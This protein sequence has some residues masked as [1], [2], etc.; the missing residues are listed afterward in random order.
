L[1][2]RWL[3]D[4]T[5]CRADLVGA[6]TAGKQRVEKLLEDACIKLPVVASGIFGVSGGR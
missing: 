6:W 1:P 5:R 4:V 3:R 2:I